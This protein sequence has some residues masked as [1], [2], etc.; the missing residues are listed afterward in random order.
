MMTLR[1]KVM[2]KYVASLTDRPDVVVEFLL[3]LILI[4][5]RHLP[6]NQ[7][8]SLAEEMRDAADVIEER[9]CLRERVK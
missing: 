9:V 4:A 5:T 1:S 2:G 6:L 8:I 7:R 3:G